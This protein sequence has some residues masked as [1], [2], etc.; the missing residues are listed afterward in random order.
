MG[1]IDQLAQHEP[2]PDLWAQQTSV[3]A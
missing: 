2:S 3:R 1:G